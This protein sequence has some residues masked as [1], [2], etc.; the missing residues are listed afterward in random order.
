M[1]LTLQL[2]LL[3][4]SEQKTD[5]LRTMEAFNAAASYA[6]QAGFEAKYFGQVNLHRMVYRTLRQRFGLSAQL[7]VR[8]IAKAVECFQ[9]D[10]TVCP[11]F[12]PRGAVTYDQRIL[13]FKGLSEV[14]LWALGGRLRL[15]F[16]CGAYQKALQGRIKGQAD[17]VYRD[18]KFYL[19]CTID[20]PDGAP[21]EVK[22]A[23]GV[24][25]GIVN[26]ATDSTG[27]V[28]TGE[29]VEKTR[30]H[31]SKRRGVLNRV[32]TKSA[33]RRL[34]K[35]RRREANFRRNE[36][37]CIAKRLVAKAKAQRCVIVLENLKGI[38]ERVTVRGRQ[39]AKHSG[40]A[41][42]QLQGFVD[43]KARLAGVPVVYV[44]P[45]NS[46][47]TCS[48]CGHC[49]KGNRQSQADF[50]C[51]HCAYSTNAD[52]NAALNLRTRAAV[53]PPTVGVDEAKTGSLLDCG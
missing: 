44:D 50:C 10:K 8:A 31:Y 41:F 36:N 1:K 2:Q 30:R 46:S 33:R 29:Q 51:R 34:S 11:T 22:D 6:A 40:W 52:Y 35:T 49:E 3:P 4:S 32:G 48:Q 13:S 26:L 7:A 14:S 37:H 23:L 45:R 43:Y 12:K 18:K 53:N 15:P 19:F 5:L 39:R 21:I 47:R 38:R 27:E 24:D 25:L 20:L 16:V 17:L 9:R 42:R 28:F